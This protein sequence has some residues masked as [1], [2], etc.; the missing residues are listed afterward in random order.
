MAKHGLSLSAFQYRLYKKA[1]RSSVRRST[2]N[3][4]PRAA[5]LPVEVVA[6][7]APRAR[8]GHLE[9]ALPR[10]LLLRFPVGTDTG[11]LAHLL[12]E[13]G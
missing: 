2:V 5:F 13:L 9:V 3:G 6:A 4:P 10:G 8:E 11:Y 7:P 1:Q 12:A